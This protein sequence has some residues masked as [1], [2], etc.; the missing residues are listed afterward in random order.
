MVPTVLNMIIMHPE[1]EKYSDTLSR[2]KVSVGGG[3]L[4]RDMA[5]RAQKLGISVMAGYGLSETAPVLTLANPTERHIGMSNEE[6]LDAVLLKTGIPI[7]LV[8]IRVVD[9]EMKDV[10]RDSK[11]AGEIVVR[12]PWLTCE[13][14]KEPA[15]TEEL[16]KGGWLHTGD[17][18]V[19]DE[20]GYVTIVDRI[21]DAIKSGGEWIPTI[22]LE[23]LL[24]RH[25]AV[26][27]AA[28]IGSRD[29]NWGE[30][31]L[32]VVALRQN[33]TVTSDELKNHMESFVTDGKIA[34]FWVP[35]HYVIQT[36]QLPKT[37][38]GKI[39]KKPLREKYSGNL[40][41]H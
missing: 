33:H 2:W 16:W 19:M 14:Y 12:G 4:P 18:A 3:A 41:I 1:V 22:I 34:K 39:D 38:T 6:I 26:I 27:E 37:S 5:L 20:E 28:V 35:E 40:V 29:P 36:E 25:P 15:K 24:V 21:K 13:Y 30:R 7:P 23:D 17:M 32:A 31:P 8:N 10:P 11:T 9:S